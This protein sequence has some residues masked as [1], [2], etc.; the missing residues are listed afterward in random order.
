MPS[1]KS[2]GLISNDN[3]TSKLF[4]SLQ[5]DFLGLDYDNPSDYVKKYWEKYETVRNNG[6]DSLAGRLFEYILATVFIR[7][8]L[9]PLY[10]SVSVAFVP[11]VVYDLMLYRND[12]VPICI[13][14]K[15]SLRERYK[16]SDLEAI[17]LKYVHRKAKCYLLTV[18]ET[19]A[20]SVKNKINNG[21]VIGLDDVIVATGGNFD[22]FVNDLKQANY[23]LASSIEVLSS[24]Y[25]ILPESI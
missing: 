18:N 14:A 6:N 3:Q 17:A 16:Q 24:N 8:G 21:S 13:S 20:A 23:G 5:G 2:I 19:E 12:K 7:E 4:E 10:Y 25:I 1:L 9:L 11:N 15:T 22:A